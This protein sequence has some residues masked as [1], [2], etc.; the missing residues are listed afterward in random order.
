MSA[1]SQMGPHSSVSTGADAGTPSGPRVKTEVGE[2]TG[3]GDIAVGGR[4][5]LAGA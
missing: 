1:E 4:G 2:T 3:V 5:T